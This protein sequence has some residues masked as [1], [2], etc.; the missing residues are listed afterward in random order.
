MKLDHFIYEPRLLGML[1]PFGDYKNIRVLDCKI[2]DKFET[3]DEVP[4]TVEVVAKTILM[5]NS[6]IANCVSMLLYNIPIKTAFEIMKKNWKRDIKYDRVIFLVIK[7]VG[8][9]S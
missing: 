9:D 6:E 1:I 4:V 2:G 5:V 8:D 3:M 7:I